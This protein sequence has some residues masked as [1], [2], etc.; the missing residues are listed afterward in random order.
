MPVF[1]KTTTRVSFY[2][3][4][5]QYTTKRLTTNSNLGNDIAVYPIISL[6]EIIIWNPTMLLIKGAKTMFIIV[7]TMILIVATMIYIVLAKIGNVL[8]HLKYI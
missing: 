2:R 6:H 8:K 1:R 4:L 5:T 7:F 3:W